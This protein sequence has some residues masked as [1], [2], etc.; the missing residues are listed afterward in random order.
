MTESDRVRHRDHG[1]EA[2]YAVVCAAELP[3]AGWECAVVRGLGSALPGEGSIVDRDGDLDIPHIDHVDAWETDLDE[4]KRITPWSHASDLQ[5]VPPAAPVH[6][7]FGDW[8]APRPGSAHGMT[9]TRATAR[10]DMGVEAAAGRVLKITWDGAD[11]VRPSFGELGCL[12]H[13][14]H[15]PRT[16]R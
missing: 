10:V 1:P 11:A 6:T 13:A 15:L 14:G 4:R 3:T 7:G 8:E 12:V 9:T 16:A 2:R 5:D